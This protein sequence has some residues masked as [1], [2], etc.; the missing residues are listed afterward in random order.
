MSLGFAY[1]ARQMITDIINM[2]MAYI[3][4]HHPDFI[5]TQGAIR[6]LM[7]EK[8]ITYQDTKASLAAEDARRHAAARQE[9]VTG[10][11][12]TVKNKVKHGYVQKRGRNF[13]WTYGKRY[14]V[15]EGTKSGPKLHYFNGHDPKEQNRGT[16]ILTNSII[17]EME[18]KFTFQ[19]VNED[20]QEGGEPI[21]WV[22]RCES[23]ED[24][25]AW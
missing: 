10:T 18:D 9:L 23:N 2:E 19:V 11:L 20:Q 14:L 6:R 3:N 4:I 5:G 12:G 1:Q 15:V 17:E 22:L 25:Q 24:M 8:Q 7:A 13:P 21:R 16:L